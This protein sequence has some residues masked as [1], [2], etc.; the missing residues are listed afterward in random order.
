M[1]A[2]SV[3]IEIEK[4]HGYAP[5]H[6]AHTNPKR[7]RGKDLPNSPALRVGSS[8]ETRP[9]FGRPVSGDACVALGRRFCVL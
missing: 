9:A 6:G 1:Y 2:E 4:R 7:K 8:A 5:S 3:H